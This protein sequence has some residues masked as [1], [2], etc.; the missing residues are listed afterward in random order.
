MLSYFGLEKVVLFCLFV[1]LIIR[2]CHCYGNLEILIY[3]LI[4]PPL[5]TFKVFMN[6]LWLTAS[7]TSLIECRFPRSIWVIV[8]VITVRF[9]CWISFFSFVFVYLENWHQNRPD[10]VCGHSILDG[11]GD[12]MGERIWTK[13]RHLVCPIYSSSWISFS[14]RN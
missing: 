9:V 14:F 6:W 1:L 8:Q 12:P 3:F 4:S 13:S 10:I 7:L 5:V 11:A 2:L